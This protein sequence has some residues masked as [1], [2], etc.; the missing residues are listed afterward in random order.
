[1]LW[2][3]IRERVLRATQQQKLHP[4]LSDWNGHATADSPAAAVYE[5]ML[6]AWVEQITRQ[7][8][9]TAARAALG[10]TAEGLLGSGLFNERYATPLLHWLETTTEDQVDKTIVTALSAASNFLTQELGPSP[11]WWAWGEVRRLELSHSLMGT[12]KAL[13]SIFQPPAVAHGGDHFTINQAGVSFFNVRKPVSSLPNL[14]MVLDCGDWSA[15]RVVLCGGQSGNPMSRNYL[16]QYEYW[17]RGEA[18]P[19][20]WT[21]E[22]ILRTTLQTLRINPLAHASDERKPD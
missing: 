20:R 9:P 1:V 18:V 13:R 21:P 4:L 6:I 12:V 10:K 17:L 14:R 2:E 7:E 22:E 16:D 3:Q 19:L 8:L 11:H 15:S 5:L